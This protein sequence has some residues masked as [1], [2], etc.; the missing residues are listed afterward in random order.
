REFH[1]EILQAKQA[2]SR[3]PSRENFIKKFH[4]QSKLGADDEFKRIPFH[5]FPTISQAVTNKISI[6]KLN[7]SILIF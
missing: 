2:G 5:S 4:K 6:T 3:G 1:Q 7:R